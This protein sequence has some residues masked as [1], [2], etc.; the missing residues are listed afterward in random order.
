MTRQFLSDMVQEEDAITHENRHLS[1]ILVPIDGM[2][3]YIGK[4]YDNFRL[5]IEELN[6]FIYIY[7]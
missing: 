6:V 3:D 7:N 2:L 1:K 4:D 5:I